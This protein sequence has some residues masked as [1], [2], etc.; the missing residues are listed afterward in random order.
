MINVNTEKFQCECKYREDVLKVHR[1][2]ALDHVC[3]IGYSSQLRND[4]PGG[5]NFETSCIPSFSER[6][7]ETNAGLNKVARKFQTEFDRK[8]LVNEIHA[9]FGTL[10]RQEGVLS[11]K[12]ADWNKKLEKKAVVYTVQSNEIG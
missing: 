2:P 9:L 1:S 3:C 8:A 7:K 6:V 4:I 12:I 5:T 11:T 10:Y